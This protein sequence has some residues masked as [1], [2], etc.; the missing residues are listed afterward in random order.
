LVQSVVASADES[1][2]VPESAAPLLLPDEEPEPEPELPLPLP[3]LL[4]PSPHVESEPAVHLPFTGLLV[5]SI[6][7]TEAA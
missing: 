7:A 2:P 6:C 4:P 5:H 1:S 3:E